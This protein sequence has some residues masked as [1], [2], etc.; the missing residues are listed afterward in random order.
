MGTKKPYP[1]ELRARAVRLVR[2][3]EAEHASRA[4][5][6]RSIASSTSPAS[7]RVWSSRSMAVS[8]PS[9]RRIGLVM[10]ITGGGAE[11]AGRIA[12]RTDSA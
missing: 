11:A 2:E 8:M 6:S 10:P 5:A 1:A 4:A 12:A 3:Q 7:A 9:V